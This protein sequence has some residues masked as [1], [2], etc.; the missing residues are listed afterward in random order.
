M[1]C[2]EAS[3]FVAL[4]FKVEGATLLLE[5]LG[6][7]VGVVAFPLFCVYIQSFQVYSCAFYCKAQSF[8]FW[9]F[10]LLNLGNVGLL[11]CALVFAFRHVFSAKRSFL[12]F[13]SGAESSRQQ[14]KGCRI[15]MSAAFCLFPG[16][17]AAFLI[18]GLSSRAPYV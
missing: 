1:S 2:F 3:G 8:T 10:W 17:Y 18:Y 5:V 14:G 6:F 15:Y 9:L 4:R 7:W 12:G 11:L 16:P 13:L